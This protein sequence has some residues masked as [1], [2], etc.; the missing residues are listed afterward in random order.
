LVAVKDYLR[1]IPNR[2]AGYDVLCYTNS[3][4]EVK[5]TLVSFPQPQISFKYLGNFDPLISQSSL[6][7]LPQQPFKLNQGLSINR[8]YLLEVNGVIV[9]EH[10]QLNWIYS[11]KAHRRETIETLASN[12][13]D[14]LQSIIAHCQSLEGQKYT[15][16]DFP[17]AN[18][19]QQNL[20]KLLAKINK[21][22]E[23]AV[24]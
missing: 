12:Y 3:N 13:I 15:P 2:G 18:L 4:Q 19:S 6:F 22:N 1:S 11:T 21:V 9:Q 17:R 14:A 23:E 24:Q 16:S 7:N 10:L 8:F 20:D 5:S